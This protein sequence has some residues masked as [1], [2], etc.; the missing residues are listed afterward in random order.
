M[1]KK[2][3]LDKGKSRNALGYANELLKDDVAGTDM[4]L[5]N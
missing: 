1:D 4:K 2:K 3:D 5:A